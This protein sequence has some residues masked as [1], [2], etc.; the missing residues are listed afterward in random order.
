MREDFCIFILTHGRAD[1]IKTIDSLQS[2]GYTGKIY[3]VIDDEDATAPDYYARYGE[4]VLMFS[5]EAISKTFDE[6]DNFKDRRTITYARNAC[7]ALAEQV[8]CRYFMQLD[9]D[10][11]RFSYKFNHINEYSDIEFKNMDVIL[12]IVIDYYI[13]TP[14][15]SI[16]FAQAGDY[17]GGSNGGYAKT[18]ST[19]RKAMNSFICSV[20]RPFK[21]RGRFNEDVNTYTTLQRMGGCFLTLL[22]LS[23][24]QVTTQSN[25]GGITDLYKKFGTYVKSFTTVIYSPSCVVVRDMSSIREKRL[26]HRINWN[27]TAPKIIRESH[28]KPAHA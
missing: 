2:R 14:F 26:H 17:L 10:Y 13:R 22:G 28:R 1:R 8:G 9:D 25:E 15:L 4:Q 5:K 24:V 6:G 12:R 20:D 3:L 21:F 23:L 27:A 11:T 7:W 19:R 16:A 18:I